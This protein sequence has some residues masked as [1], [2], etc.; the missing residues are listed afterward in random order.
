MPLTTEKDSV[1]NWQVHKIAVIGPGIVGMPMAALLAS[2][3][4][5]KPEDDRAKVVVVQ[6]D[7]PTSGWKVDAINSGLSSVRGVEPGLDEI[8]GEAVEH[9]ALSASHDYAELRDAD[10]V[11]VCVQT[12]KKG[13]EPDYG[14]LFSAL[15]ALALELKRKPA[16]NIPLI[17]IESTLA[18]STM[19]TLIRDHFEAHGL[20]DGRDVLLGFSPNRVMPGRLVERVRTSDKLVSGMLPMTARLIR[21]LYSGIVSSGELHET[22]TLTAEIV[23][24]TENAYRDVRIAYAAEIA[25]FC[26]ACNV[27]FFRLRDA[28]NEHLGQS[29]LASGDSNAV[30]NG[31]LLVP[32]VGVGGHC[33]PKD[34]ILLLWRRI[35]HGQRAANSLIEQARQ[36]NDAS[37]AW[38]VGLAET[39]CGDLGNRNVAVLGA[40][41]RF[42]SEDTRNSPSLALAKELLKRG[43]NVRLHDPYVNRTDQNL[44]RLGLIE[45]F[46]NDLKFA[47][48]NA[49]VLIAATA[50][51]DYIEADAKIVPFALR[52]NAVVDACNIWS[53]ETFDASVKYSGIGRGT[54]PPDDRLID[55]VTQG[56]RIVE[57]GFARELNDT[58]DFLNRRYAGDEFNRVNY[59]DVQK[60]AGT[61]STGCRLAEPIFTASLD[62]YDG[63]RPTLVEFASVKLMS[64]AM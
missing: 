27:D 2:A 32:T 19:R 41:Y 62:A 38:T 21:S 15:E 33:L 12:D 10:V 14:P 11:L 64:A 52:L 31:G 17:I 47:V 8:V 29:D 9:G 4:I 57:H 34:G 5:K 44:K 3:E 58:L 18:P 55:F 30:P 54:Q 22:N 13:L 61:C 20:R 43:A 28:V 7:S 40:A 46:T 36:I 60:L 39:L 37:P 63:F 53:R 24:T 26:D 49:E 42:N 50:H 6:R 23:K 48:E 59:G 45:N 1:Q 25:R 16:G 51:H 35:E 56:F